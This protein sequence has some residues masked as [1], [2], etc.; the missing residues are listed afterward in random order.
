[1]M[2]FVDRHR[3]G[4]ILIVWLFDLAFMC[5]VAGWENAAAVLGAAFFT[6]VVTSLLPSA[7]ILAQQSRRESVR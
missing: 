7:H 6:G 1:M 2:S 4:L 5:T 3:V